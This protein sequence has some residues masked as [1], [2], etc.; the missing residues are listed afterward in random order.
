MNLTDDWMRKLSPD[1]GQARTGKTGRCVRTVTES[2]RQNLRA[3]R[4]STKSMSSF[5]SRREP[6]SRANAVALDVTRHVTF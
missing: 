2:P 1:R 6:K 5:S 4:A 3:L